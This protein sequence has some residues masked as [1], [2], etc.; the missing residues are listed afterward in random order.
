VSELR[1][2][3]ERE[4]A[5]IGVVITMYPQSRAMKAEAAAAGFYVSAWGKHLRLPDAD[6]SCVSNNKGRPR[7][8]SST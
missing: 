4:K 5:V 7:A 1:G 3:I 2:V 6:H 8:I